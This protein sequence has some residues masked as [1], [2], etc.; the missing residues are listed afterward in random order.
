MNTDKR[1]C[2]NAVALIGVHRRSSV[3]PCLAV[4]P[5]VLLMCLGC[6][7]QSAD[8]S[9][10]P[11]FASLVPLHT[12][13]GKPQPGD[14]LDRHTELGQT[15]EHYTNSWP[16]TPDEQ[17]HVIYVQ[18]L[19]NFRPAERKIVEQAAEFLGVYFQLPVKVHKGLPLSVIP[20]KAWRKRAPG[21]RTR[22]SRGMCLTNCSLPGCPK[23]P[24][25]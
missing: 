7:A 10:P 25:R 1:R 17:R 9:L 16:V 2:A 24:S 23:T 22:F 18:P 13:L 15:Y 3:V 4:I 8:P 5:C 14:W 11:R 12:R 6:S 19:G 21:G 20:R